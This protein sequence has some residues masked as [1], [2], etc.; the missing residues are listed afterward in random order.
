MNSEENQL[1]SR[2]QEILKLVI[3]YQNGD[4]ESGNQVYEIFYPVIYKM[5]NNALDLEDY[6]SELNLLFAKMLNDYK[7]N[8]NVPF[9]AWFL[10]YARYHKLNGY[11]KKQHE[12]NSKAIS[13][14]TGRKLLIKGEPILSL[15]KDIPGQ[16]GTQL[17]NIIKDPNGEKK[18]DKFIMQE[19]EASLRQCNLNKTEMFIC[20]EI[21]KGTKKLELVDMLGIPKHQ[22]YRMINAIDKKYPNLKYEFMR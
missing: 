12:D 15:N 3:Q 21:A 8:S 14:E 11:N 16:K 22:V 7:I 6:E 2:E 18:S 1:Y 4:E 20:L 17:G 9:A 13:Y 19:I 5:I 10:K